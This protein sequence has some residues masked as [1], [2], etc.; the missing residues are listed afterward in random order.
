MSGDFSRHTFDPKRAF[1]AVLMQ[2]GRVSLD[3]DWNEQVAIV[4]RRLRAETVDIIGRCAVPRET[5]DGFAIAI[6]GAGNSKALSI[7]RGRIY[8]HG[9]LAEN[10]GEPPSSFDLATDRPDGSGPV[11]VLAEQI[12]ANS[13]SFTAQP[14]VPAPAAL[15]AGDGPHLVYLDVWQREVGYLEEPRILEKALGGVD[16]TTRLQTV[17]QVKLLEDVGAGVTCATPEA[18]I[19]GW[20]DT[21]RPSGGRLSTRTAAVQPPADPC[22]VPPQSGYRGLENQLY[23]LEIHDPGPPGTA[24]FK[25][26]R[27]NAVV[28]SRLTQI[29]AADEVEVERVGRDDVLRF[30][31]GDWVEITDDRRELAG[32]AGAMRRIDN[33][34]DE[35][36]RIRLNAPLPADLIPS[37]AGDDTLEARHTRIRRWDQGGRVFDENGNELVDLDDPASGG[38]IPVPAAGT[39][40]VNLE[41]GIQVAFEIAGGGGAFHAM[42]RWNFAARTADGSIEILD[43]APPQGIHHHY[44][45]L[46]VVTFP[47][48][49]DDCRILWPPE[50]AGAGCACSVCVTAE[51]HNAGTLT[52][53]HAIDQVRAIGGTVCLGPGQYTLGASPVRIDGARSVRIIG[54]GRATVLSYAGDGAAIVIDDAVGVRCEA[55]TVLFPPRFVFGHTSVG[56]GPGLLV[57]NSFAVT[58]ERCLIAEVGADQSSG[59]AIALDGA[60]FYLTL[61]ENALVAPN[62]IGGGGQRP[63]LLLVDSDIRDNQLECS[64]RGISFTG[65]ALYAGSIRLAGNTIRG[66]EREGIAVA[67]GTIE[68]GRCEITGNLVHGAGTGIA[69]ATGTARITG[70]DITTL[71]GRRPGRAAG[72]VLGEGLDPGGIR[73]CAVIGNR[74]TGTSGYGIHVTG[75]IQR[76]MIKN[77]AIA[78]TGT[79]GIVMDPDASASALSIEN[80]QLAD[81]APAFDDD[82]EPVAA[83]RLI[84]A[85]GILLAGNTVAGVGAASTSNPFRAALDLL[86]C[87]E[88]RVSGN[89][90]SAVG[91]LATLTGRATAAVRVV[92][93][94]GDVQLDGNQIRRAAGDPQPGTAAGDW[95]ALLVQ[96]T[97]DLA[98]ETRTS[99]AIPLTVAAKQT[100]FSIGRQRAFTWVVAAPVNAVVRGNEA[101]SWGGDLPLA[102]VVIT[103]GCVFE[104]NQVLLL[105]ASKA[106]AVV[107]LAAADVAAANNLVRREGDQDALHIDSTRFTVLGNLTRGEIRVLTLSPPTL[108]APWD[109]LNIPS[110]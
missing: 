67:G 46:A 31:D 96:E 87:R 37:G 85:D 73:D 49:V 22:L 108:P 74:I 20:L 29:H 47:A 4:E 50:A 99:L 72:I 79:G 43:Q 54:Q 63:Y 30:N 3:A 11:G 57:R 8:V 89:D 27:D 93:R 7:G 28:A 80:N 109:Q 39:P 97:A 100:L 52:I 107:R 95:L 23:R 38:V 71:A 42:D 33:V 56:G 36:R 58:V 24:T 14:H 35:T 103:G 32:A 6:A 68:A 66:A 18:Q 2:Q 25:W 17:W 91:P 81:I 61:R 84:H 94:R 15:P 110:A 77:N 10:F 86:L 101:L 106:P 19:P 65:T 55:L 83:I 41:H 105:G 16:T 82:R 75:P 88:V 76:T 44:C 51:S 102:V 26:S 53:Q 60:L 21:T 1:G 98:T 78:G 90:L 104:G 12:G 64:R 48:T 69:L 59:T 40:F 45:R 34:S 70:N 62:G 92:G 9:L 5:P 13:V